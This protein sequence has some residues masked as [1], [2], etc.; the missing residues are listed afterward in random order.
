MEVPALSGS[1]VPEITSLT[2]TSSGAM[3]NTSSSNSG[4]KKGGGGGGGSKKPAEKPKKSDVVERYKEIN[5]L[6]DD[7]ADKMND[8]SKAAN[9]LYGKG[10]LDL[11]KKN[12]ELLKQEI[13]L[14]KKKKD[15]A[16]KYLEEDKQALFDAAADA[17][18]MLNIDENGLITNYTEAMTELY[19]ELDAEIE[20]ANKDGNVS[21]AE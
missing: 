9:R 4:G 7:L 14:T 8:A 16:L 17:G 5:D 3:N 12:N 18:V 20:A 15:E 19:N 13:D 1:G 10:R 6:I 21:E 11:M 2:K